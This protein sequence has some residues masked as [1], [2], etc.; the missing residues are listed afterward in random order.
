M[1]EI[2]ADDVEFAKWVV[3]RHPIAYSLGSD[4][5]IGEGLVGLCRAGL[6]YRP[7]ATSF[8]SYAYRRI[9]GAVQDAARRNDHLRRAHRAAVTAGRCADEGQPLY[10]EGLAANVDGWQ[11]E[12]MIGSVND[13]DVALR[14]TVDEAVNA[15]EGTAGAVLRMSL[16][17]TP[18]IEIAAFLGVSESRVSHLM[19]EARDA[20]RDKLAARSAAELLQQ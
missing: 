14:I 4:D 18:Q 20:L 16:H 7:G 19:C 10:L 5:A 11:W 6:T 15:L 17:D 9:I 13:G 1:H 12:D 3:L 8:R 2:T